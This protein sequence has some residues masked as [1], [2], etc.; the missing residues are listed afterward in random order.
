MVAGRARVVSDGVRQP[1]EIVRAPRA[2][3]ASAGFVPPV[4]HVAFDELPAG[5]ADELRLREV[6]PRERQRHAVLDLIAKPESAARLIVTGPGPEPAAQRLV[7]E[8]PV[9]HQVERIVGR[10][11]LDGAEGFV[12]APANALER[13]L[14]GLD[15][16]HPPDQIS[17]RV[18]VSRLPQQEHQPAGLPWREAHGDMQGSARI[19]SGAEAVG[20]PLMGQR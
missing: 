15:A 4:L 2:Q 9:H 16:A 19:E 5:R 3:P 12:P 18:Q 7:L 14:G 11:N 10:S 13:L 8:P 17:H 6:G 20:Q 1:E